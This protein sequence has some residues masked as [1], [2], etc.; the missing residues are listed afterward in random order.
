VIKKATYDDKLGVVVTIFRFAAIT[1]CRIL[2]IQI[3]SIKVVLPEEADSAPD[4]SL[5]SGGIS[6]QR[7]EFPGTFIPASNGQQG[8]EISV[9]GLQGRKLAIST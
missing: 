8:L 5:P 4:E 9:V 1:E 7:A 6:D 3:E 2:P